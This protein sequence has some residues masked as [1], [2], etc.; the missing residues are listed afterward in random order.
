MLTQTSV[1]KAVTYDL[2][3]YQRRKQQFLQQ[4]ERVSGRAC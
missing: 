4:S 3:V 1:L 2:L